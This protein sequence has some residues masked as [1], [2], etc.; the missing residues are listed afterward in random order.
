MAFKDGLWIKAHSSTTG[1]GS[2]VISGALT[3]FYTPLEKI[4]VGNTFLYFLHDANGLGKEFGLGT[5]NANFTVDRTTIIDS[6]NAGSAISLTSGEHTIVNAPSAGYATGSVNF[7]DSLLQRPELK[8]Y[9]ETVTSPAIVAGVLTLNIENGNVFDVAW[10]ANITSIVIQ[11]P[12]PTGKAC[13]FTLRMTQ[14][15][16]G[17]RTVAIPVSCT[18]TNGGTTPTFVTTANKRTTLVFMT[19]SAGTAYDYSLVGTGY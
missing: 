3:G 9:S 14:D 10:N 16:T 7:L 13:S 1:T 4:G 6:T 17:G 8:D 11:N 12:S 15:A 19:V 5:V 2:L 18:C